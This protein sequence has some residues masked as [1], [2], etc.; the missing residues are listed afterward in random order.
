MQTGIAVLEV[1]LSLNKV[2]VDV[3]ALARAR[4][5][6][7]E[8]LTIPYLLALLKDAGFKAGKR[9]VSSR[10]LL[11][12]APLPAITILKDGSYAIVL[13]K[14]NNEEEKSFLVY[15]PVS[16]KV[17]SISATQW[18][19]EYVAGVIF[20]SLRGISADLRFGFGWFY[21]EILKYKPLIAQVVVA[22]F[23]V[24]IF[25]MIT[26]L[27]TQV[28]IDKVLYHRSI[29]TLQIIMVAYLTVAVFELLL[30]TSRNYLFL[31]TSRKID[32]RLGA[33]LFR[34]LV[35]LPIVFF[36]NRKV[37]NIITRVREIDGIR[38]FITNKT[39]SVVLDAFFSVSFLVIMLFYSPALTAISASF[40]GAVAL[41]FIVITPLYRRRLDDFFAAGAQ[42]NSFLVESV[43]GIHTIKSL[44][45]EGNLNRKWEDQV[46]NFSQSNFH[47]AKVS[48]FTSAVMG[49][50]QKLM[51]IAILYMGVMSVIEG[52]LTVGQLIAFQMFA[53]QLTG[54]LLRLVGLWPE[55]QQNML[56][57]GRLAEILNTPTEV[58][59]SSGISLPRLEGRIQFEKVSFRYQVDGPA[60]LKT[61]S[62]EIA[63]GSYTAFVGR[64]GSGK[65][66]VGKL[67]QRLYLPQ[68]GTIFVDTVDTKHMNPMWLRQNIGIVIQDSFLFS[69]TIR[70][71]IA[72]G[73][74]NVG[75]ERIIEATQLAG[76]HDFIARMAKGYDTVVGE[77]GSALSG[78]QRQRVA[79]ARALLANPKILILD[80]AT[81][82][83]DAESEAVIYK[84]LQKIRKNRTIIIISHK[85]ASVKE[86]DA[87]FVLDE[88][89]LRESGVHETL[90]SSNGIYHTFYQQQDAFGD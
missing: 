82:A 72:I 86:C 51:S 88:G 43:T 19:A 27:F 2:A 87:I 14:K 3:A 64:S 22:S 21:R 80:E 45:L 23:V 90:M 37:G 16:K 54:P 42:A 30:G 56:A 89:E 69:G 71:N 25:G 79:I 28:V 12:K 61:I 55:L 13:Q 26:P 10:Y 39:I 53:G 49:W 31:H 46:A 15:S 40:I 34:H 73:L 4:G 58:Q 60:V 41:L 66:T 67:I 11:E 75:M 24:Q 74:P 65:S 83:L 5:V 52:K 32:A 47:L 63:A 50:L 7:S 76:A 6:G 57:V 20:F 44:A 78:G 38:E 85:L 36:E 59:V 8:E 62:L 1:A 81:S 35:N 84:T 17:A 29:S 18:E 77:R 70:E 68:E 9:E 48:Q 33:S